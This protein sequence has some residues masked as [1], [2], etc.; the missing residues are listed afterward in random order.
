MKVSLKDKGVKAVVKVAFPDYKGRKVKV[1]AVE[2]VDV[3]DLNWSGG[4]KNEYRFINADDL[5]TAGLPHL[6]PWNNVYEGQR[7][8]MLKNSIV[9]KRCYFCGHDLGLTI[10]VHPD[11]MPR[12]IEGA[13]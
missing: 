7:F 11:L 3:Y 10:Y 4:T 13:K 12:M 6:A 9:V 5:N 2:K 8:T 1:E